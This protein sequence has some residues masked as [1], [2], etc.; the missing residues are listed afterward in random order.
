MEEPWDRYTN[1]AL[2]A[3]YASYFIPEAALLW[4]N[5]PKEKIPDITQRSNLLTPHPDSPG[6][7]WKNYNIPCLAYATQRITE[8]IDD[9]DLPW[10]LDHSMTTPIDGGH[11]LPVRKK[12][13]HRALKAWM[14]KKFPNEKPAF[15]FTDE[16]RNSYAIKTKVYQKLK[17]E[18]DDLEIRLK[19][20]TEYNNVLEGENEAL[21]E[22]YDELKAEIDKAGIPSEQSEITY[23]NIINA[24]LCCLSGEVKGAVPHPSFVNKSNKFVEAKVMAAI[25]DTFPDTGT[26]SMRTFQRHFPRAKGS[27]KSY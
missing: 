4:C 18:R 19:V 12:I 20:A 9:G 23:L 3:H 7:V 10:E 2:E 27:F 17:K 16:E 5:V 21:K 6:E 11:V 22:K 26:L 24:L 15:L 14:E 8:A 13:L 25:L 1:P